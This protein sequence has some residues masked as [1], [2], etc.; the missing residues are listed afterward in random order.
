MGA[1]KKAVRRRGPVE[2]SE[3]DFEVRDS[4]IPK[5]GKGLFAIRLIR[6][7]DTIGFYLGKIINDK[8]A[9]EEPYISSRYLVYV[10][11]DHWIEGRI[12][13]NYT[14]FINHSNK[15]NAELVTSVRWKSA[16]IKALKLIRPGDEIFFDYG[17]DYWEALESELS[18]VE[19]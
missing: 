10:C 9:E 1:K 6:P 3:S 18:P 8:M 16:R 7:G 4:S 2:F 11:A 14:R 12:D 5:I 15:P 19:K 13:G 17:E